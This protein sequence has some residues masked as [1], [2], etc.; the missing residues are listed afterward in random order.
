M[1]STF[2]V[3]SVVL[4]DEEEVD[5]STL[6]ESDEPPDLLPLQAAI[7]NEMVRAKNEILNA[8]FMMFLFKMLIINKIAAIVFFGDTI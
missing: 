8:F 1:V 6:V 3:V 2:M 4:L 7:D 5:E